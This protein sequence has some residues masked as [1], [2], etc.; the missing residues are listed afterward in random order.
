MNALNKLSA[1]FQKD[2]WKEDKKGGVKN[3]PFAFLRVIFSSISGF[4]NDR[5]F[6]KGYTLTYY[7]LLSLVPFLAIGFAI[8]QHLGFEEKF[9]EQVKEQLQ[10]QPKVAEK[11]IEFS[12]TTLKQTQGGII[13]VFGILVLV[14]TVFSMIG[15]IEEY[16]DEIWKVETPRTF[17]QQ[18]KSYLPMIILFPVFLVGSSSL[19]IYAATFT[20]SQVESVGFLQPF[21]TWLKTI[22]GILPH[23]LSWVFFSFIYIYLP[24]RKVLWRAGIIAGIIA[25]ILYLMWQWIYIKFQVN[26]ASYGAIYGSFAAVPLF[27]I[28][29]NYSWLIILFGTELAA[30]IQKEL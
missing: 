2:L 28:W 17:W 23:L 6:E 12:N 26:A 30:N 10:S 9:V 25:G 4:F 27:L 16:F 5:C 24:N 22:F 3:L 1:F 14:Y 8:A 20:T 7:T 13:A 29:L 21:S 11:I 19:L 18:V 15:Y